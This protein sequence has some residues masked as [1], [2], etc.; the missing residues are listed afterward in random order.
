MNFAQSNV[1]VFNICFFSAIMWLRPRRCFYGSG[2]L[3]LSLIFFR[4]CDHIL[5]DNIETRLLKM[6]ILSCLFYVFKGG[7]KYF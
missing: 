4:A 1:Y 6:Y 5:F 7:I 3:G 2:A